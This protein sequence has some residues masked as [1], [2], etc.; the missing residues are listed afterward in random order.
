MAPGGD[1]SDGLRA[2]DDGGGGGE[3]RQ[4]VHSQQVQAGRRVSLHVVQYHAQRGE[5]PRQQLQA[6][7]HSRSHS[8]T[9]GH[10]HCFTASLLHC[11]SYYTVYDTQ[12]EDC[13]IKVLLAP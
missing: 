12:Y 3:L 13:C 5:P 9:F 1:G 10:I 4:R 11:F 8:H 2:L 6:L 7:S